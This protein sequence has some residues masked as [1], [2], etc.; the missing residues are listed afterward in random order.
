MGATLASTV[1]RASVSLADEASEVQDEDIFQFALNLEYMEAEYY[2]RGTTGKGIHDSDAGAD[3]GQVTGGKQVSFETPA[4]GEFMAEVAENE[5]A[6]VRFYRKTLGDQAVPRPTIDFEAGFAAVA[7]AAALG[8]DFDPFGNETNFVLGGMLFEDVGVTAYAGAATVLKNKD[9]LAAA[10]GILAVEAYHMGMAR[11]TLYRK[12]EQAWKAANAVSDARDKI[13]GS[14]DKD[15]GIQIDGKANIV[16]STPDAIAF[17]RTPQEVL[18]IVYLT[19]QE[20]AS[21]GGFYP[22][23]MNGKIKST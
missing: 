20:G 12:G 15:Q 3:A 5:L 18:R 14:D 1:G 7:K 23:G 13:D 16:P 6:H 22:N 10:A 21:K 8:E 17:T 11:S 4:I 9:F 2:L 19:D